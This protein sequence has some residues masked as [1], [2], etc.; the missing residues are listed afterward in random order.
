MEKEPWHENLKKL[1]FDTPVEA[2]MALWLTRTTQ[3]PMV[4]IGRVTLLGDAVH[5]MPSDKGLGGNH[6]LEDARL[7]SKLLR[8]S[9]KPIDLAGLIEKYER[10]MFTRVKVAV[11]E[12]ENAAEYFRSLRPY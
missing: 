8:S 10:E 7:L 9:P 12:S 5:A 2:I 4:P 11:Q 1:V 6:A 3:F